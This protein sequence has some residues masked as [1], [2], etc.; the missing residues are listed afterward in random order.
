MIIRIA[1]EKDIQLIADTY[2]R[3]LTYEQANVAHSNW[4]LNVY[5]TIRV[6]IA[7]IPTR[8]MYVLE[9]N[10]EICASMVLNKE[11]A[12][13]YKEINWHYPAQKEQVMVIHTLCIPPDKSGKG[14]G[15]R[16]VSFAKEKAQEQNCKVIRIDTYAYNEPAKSLYIK[17][18][19]EISGYGET[20]L[21]GLIREEQVY[22]ECNI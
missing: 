22:M 18:G 9:D 8:T 5:P 21:E 17:N 20:L 13:A 11:Q 6:P 16:M 3:L 7:K 2:T 12:D 14:Y 10:G 19:F 4:K 15:S 1:E